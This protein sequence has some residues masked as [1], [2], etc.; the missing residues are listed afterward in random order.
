MTLQAH[1][2]YTIYICWINVG[3]V[4]TVPS[5]CQFKQLTTKSVFYAVETIAHRVCPG[6]LL[7]DRKFS[8]LAVVVYCAVR[9]K[10]IKFRGFGKGVWYLCLAFL[11]LCFKV[12]VVGNL[13][14]PATPTLVATVAAILYV[15]S[16]VIFAHCFMSATL[17]LHLSQQNLGHGYAHMAASLWYHLQYGIRPSISLCNALYISNKCGY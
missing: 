1:G 7:G 4:L 8:P 17:F 6:L 13:P 14:V 3:A 10:F 16:V 2:L 9:L 5:A 15:D 11:I 12:P